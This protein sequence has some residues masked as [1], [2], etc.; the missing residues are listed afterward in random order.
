MTDPRR[1]TAQYGDFRGEA[2]A[3]KADGSSLHELASELGVR[4][5]P[6]GL[7]VSRF[8]DSNP[9]IKDDDED[10]F[11]LNIFTADRDAGWGVDSVN[12]YVAQHGGTLLVTEHSTKIG[13]TA[14]LN[15]FKRFNITLFSKHIK[16]DG[17]EIMERI[18][19]DDERAE[20]EYYESDE[21]E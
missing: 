5:F 3:D 13:V 11:Y 10:Q 15:I 21:E 16:A 18:S 14:L 8:H 12:Q 2:A 6:I 20:R 9:R 1:A 7:S 19:L 4:G 17:M